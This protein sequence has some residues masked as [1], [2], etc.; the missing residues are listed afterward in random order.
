MKVVAAIISMTL[1]F[2]TY[3]EVKKDDQAKK[4]ITK[5]ESNKDMKMSELPTNIQEA[6]KKECE[7]EI[8]NIRKVE[9]NKNIYYKVTEMKNNKAK[10]YVFD[11]TGKKHK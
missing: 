8:T 5:P 10:V 6:I 7:G 1:I 3:A 9:V 4:E 2:G 11:Q